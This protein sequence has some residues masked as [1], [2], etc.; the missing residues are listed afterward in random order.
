MDYISSFDIRL[1]KNIFM[2]IR[3]IAFRKSSVIT[4]KETYFAGESIEGSV[5]LENTENIKIK[6]GYFKLEEHFLA[7]IVDITEESLELPIQTQLEK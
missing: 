6:G 1:G 2:R 7:L 5:L 3:F 4:G